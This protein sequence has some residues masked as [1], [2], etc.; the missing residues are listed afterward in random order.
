MWSFGLGLYHTGVEFCGREYTFSSSGV[1]STEPRH[2]PPAVFRE[3]IVVG[4]VAMGSKDVEDIVND[5]RQYFPGEDYH[6][7]T[8]N[9]NSFSRALSR[10]ILK[11]DAMPGWINRLANLGSCF[12]CLWP[13]EGQG[14]IE[15]VPMMQAQA[16][17]GTGRSLGNASGGAGGAG[18]GAA[19]GSGG[20][21]GGNETMRE[22]MARAAEARFK[23][24]EPID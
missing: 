6:V 15:G 5:L 17:S 7:V 18:A 12:S 14:G 16:F 9:C 8:K 11:K 19:G 4:E 20:G 22:R 24:A 10:A 1:F 13:K 2:A 21:G 23:S 3:A